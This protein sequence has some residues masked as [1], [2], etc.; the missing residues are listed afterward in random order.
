M[1]VSLDL[2]TYP[3][4][5]LKDTKVSP[6]QGYFLL[7]FCP[8]LW[9]DKIWPRHVARVGLLLTEV[10]DTTSGDMADVARCHLRRRTTADCVYGA[11]VDWHQTAVHAVHR[12]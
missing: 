8:K 4:L 11:M 2:S 9:T 3:T 12:R 10:G 5:Y 1:Q 7:E 6:K